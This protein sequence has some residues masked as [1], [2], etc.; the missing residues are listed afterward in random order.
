MTINKKKIRIFADFAG[1]YIWSDEDFEIP[2][3]FPKLKNDFISWQAAFENNIKPLGCDDTEESISNFDWDS[4]NSRGI[5]L[6]RRLK[7]EIG[8]D[9]IVVYERAFEED[10]DK[11]KGNPVLAVF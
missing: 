6:A 11:L 9:Y 1:G 3:I 7:N 5:E 8:S 10:P 4:F 2:N